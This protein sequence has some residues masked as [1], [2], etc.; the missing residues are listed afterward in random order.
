MTTQK[1]SLTINGKPATCEVDV[2][3]SLLDLLREQGYTSVKEGCGVGE[4]GACTVLVDG[5]A[6][7]A[8]LCLA[9]RAAGRHIRTTEGESENG[10]LSAVQQAYLD[11]GAVQC[12]F[13]TPGL[14]MTST[15]FVEKHAG[16]GKVSRE[17]IRREHAG[18]L[19]RCTG[20][21][22][23]VRAVEQCLEAKAEPVQPADAC[24]CNLP[25]A[26]RQKD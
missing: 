5:K 21:E 24:A 18:N 7:D 2:R 1:I 9:V 10:Q 17:T 11:T 19:C 14:I 4:C 16:R 13:C 25:K 20:Y 23:L 12:G 3:Q 15:A 8:C 22:G 26:D 6:M